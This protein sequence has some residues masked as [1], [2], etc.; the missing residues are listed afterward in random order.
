MTARDMVNGIG[1]GLPRHGGTLYY[2]HRMIDRFLG[3]RG[4]RNACPH[5]SY[6]GIG[7]LVERREE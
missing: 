3:C 1:K 5:A 2:L 7:Y 6:F 4:K